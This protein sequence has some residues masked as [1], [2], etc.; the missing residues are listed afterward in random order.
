MSESSTDAPATVEATVVDAASTPAPVVTQAEPTPAA[1]EPK[2]VLD[3]VTE[4]LKPDKGVDAASPAAAN[5]SSTD[6][7][8]T[9]DKPSAE[10]GKDELSDEEKK[11][12]SEGA[13]KRIRELVTTKNTLITERD[14]FKGKADNFDKM[15]G[16]LTRHGISSEE[17]NNSLEITRLI[18]AG[19]YTKAR[20][21][22]APIWAELQKRAGDVLDKDLQEEVRLGQ[23]PLERAQETQRLRASQAQTETQRQTAERRQADEQQK[24]AWKA[25]VDTVSKAAD[26]WAKTQAGSDPD[27]EKKAPLVA[28]IVEL[29]LHRRGREGFG[30]MTPKDAVA[31]SD[32]ALAEVNKR[33]GS[34]RPAPQEV[35]PNLG[36]GRSSTHTETKP[37]T[38]LEAVNQALGG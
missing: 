33:W 22:M 30:Q 37:K 31:I 17:A 23:T 13:Q 7:V 10:G 9:Q 29:E 14:G 26:D 21:V 4:A 3:A 16:F 28:E 24:S 27:W 6:E 36:N 19:D 25:H 34:L 8:K 1:K 5:R 11:T 12:F 32:R 2:S 18:K 38:A 15:T 35:R 20:D